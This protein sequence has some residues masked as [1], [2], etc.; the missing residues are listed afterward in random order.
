MML[1]KQVMHGISGCHPA[2]PGNVGVQPKTC[3]LILI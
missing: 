3:R 1:Y 2:G